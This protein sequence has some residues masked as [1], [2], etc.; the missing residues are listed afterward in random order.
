VK[1]RISL[2]VIDGPMPTWSDWRPFDKEPFFCSKKAAEKYLSN[3]KLAI[4]GLM[5]LKETT[6]NSIRNHFGIIF[7][8]EPV[9][10]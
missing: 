9:Q 4:C 10:A 5:S 8:V 2:N 3:T 7:R 1:F 6:D